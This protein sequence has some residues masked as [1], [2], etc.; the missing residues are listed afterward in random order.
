MSYLTMP[1]NYKAAGS[2]PIAEE[3]L[4]LGKQL[5]LSFTDGML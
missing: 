4:N 3:K 2:I 1:Q 5:H